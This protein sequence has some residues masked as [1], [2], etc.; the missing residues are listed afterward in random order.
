MIRLLA[1]HGADLDTQDR[2]GL[3]PLHR[4]TYEGKV[5]ALKALLEAGAVPSVTN[6]SGHTAFEI[7]RKEARHY[8]DRA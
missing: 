1:G 7:P 3:T 8:K 6:R 5:D 2:K 4:A